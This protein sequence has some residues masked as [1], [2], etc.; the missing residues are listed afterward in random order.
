MY[1]LNK[2]AF[3]SFLAQLRRE[4]GMTQ[5]ELAACLY[6]SDKAVSKWERGLSVPDISLLVPLAEQLNVTVAEL[7]QGCRVEEEQRFTREET[8]ELIRKALTFSAEPPERRQA[9]TQ[10]FLPLYGV[11][12][13]LGLVETAAVWAV[14]LAGTEGA[15]MLLI[16]N[17]IFGI[18]YGA[19]TLFWMPETLPR[20]YDENHV[21]NFAQG[22]FHMHIP[23]VYY[24]NR[25]WLHVLKAMRVWCVVSMLLTPL[26]TAAA[27][28]FEQ[29]TGW[30]VWGAVLIGYIAS[31]FGAIVIPAAPAAA[32]RGAGILPGQ[33]WHCEPFAGAASGPGEGEPEQL[34]LPYGRPLRH[35][36]CRTAGVCSVPAGAGDQQGRT[37][38]LFSA[39]H[40]LRRA[41]DRGKGGGL[42]CSLRCPGPGTD[43]CAL[44]ADLHDTGRHGGTAGCAAQPGAGA[45]DAGQAL[46]GAVFWLRL[47]RT[48][49]AAAGEKPA[50]AGC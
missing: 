26:C 15:M 40:R 13:V 5:K 17:V 21:C 14:G 41:G 43:R 18:V 23:G 36:R 44:G 11:N 10:K 47:C 35:P 19:Y 7:L 20:Y 34:S 48:V 25:N 38:E 50:L 49:L 31:L 29:A 37:G 46:A 12:V 45:P 4:K 9:R 22:A 8:E 39:A 3:G 33:H 27:V 28:V 1:E 30:Q 32:D 42:S 16:I 2:I 6:V 24:N